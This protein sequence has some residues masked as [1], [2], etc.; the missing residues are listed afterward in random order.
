MTD[1]ELLACL[2]ALLFASGKPVSYK[3]LEEILDIGEDKLKEN[4]SKLVPNN[5][6]ITYYYSQSNQSLFPNIN[7]KYP[8]PGYPE[9]V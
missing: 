9:G 2:E 4:L 7:T 3:L 8:L 5:N 1:E 6:N